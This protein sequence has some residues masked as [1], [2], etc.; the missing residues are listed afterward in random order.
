[1]QKGCAR[2]HNLAERNSMGVLFLW[3]PHRSPILMLSLMLFSPHFM[4]GQK[5]SAIAESP[6]ELPDA[7]MPSTTAPDVQSRF[8]F[9][10]HDDRLPSRSDALPSR[11]VG[12]ADSSGKKGYLMGSTP[13]RWISPGND[14]G[15][16][17]AVPGANA[18]DHLSRHLPFAKSVIVRGS[19]LARAH[20]HVARLIK[21]IKPKL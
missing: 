7:P 20:P 1:M 13:F 3:F 12:P 14:H 4:M 15:N 2:I 11:N 5:T 18:W 9:H 19:R 10:L 17:A 6:V 16:H 21:V 8:D